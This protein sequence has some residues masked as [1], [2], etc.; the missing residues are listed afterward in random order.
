ML[1]R[2]LI[3]DDNGE[4]RG[5]LKAFLEA[6]KHEVHVADDGAQAFA[7]AEKVVPHL[8]IMDVVMPGVYG[9]TAAKK[10]QE[11]WR[12]A[13]IPIIIMSGT[14]D[15]SVLESL[16]KGPQ[17]RFLRK[18]VSLKVLDAAIREM[19]PMGGYTP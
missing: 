14:V 10:F 3:A 6:R 18:P 16:P 19:L 15:Q 13:K 1:A 8:I 7:I 17:I 12:T 2:I 9:T 11:Y 5:M 4:V